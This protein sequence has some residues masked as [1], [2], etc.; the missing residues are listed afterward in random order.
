MVHICQYYIFTTVSLLDGNVHVAIEKPQVWRSAFPLE[1][2]ESRSERSDQRSWSQ[3]SEKKP[4]KKNIIHSSFT[5]EGCGCLSFIGK[6]LVW[7]RKGFQNAN[8]R[9]KLL[10]LKSRGLQKTATSDL[11]WLE[12]FVFSF[13]SKK[14]IRKTCDP[15]RSQHCCDIHT[16]LLISSRVI[17]HILISLL[18]PYKVLFF[19]VLFV[20]VIPSTMNW[21]WSLVLL[22][23]FQKDSLF[24]TSACF[25]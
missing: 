8:F 4:E 23:V 5:P 24:A 1:A 6:L 12:T 19:V 25:T 10:R 20:R 14:E 9:M 17:I 13:M 7:L 15:R 18:A 21:P 22:H 11:F 16:C 3:A 2:T